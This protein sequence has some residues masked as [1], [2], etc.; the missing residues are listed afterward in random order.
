[1]RSRVGEECASHCHWCGGRHNLEL[2]DVEGVFLEVEQE[3]PLEYGSGNG[4]NI[5][6]GAEEGEGEQLGTLALK[7]A[8]GC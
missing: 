5:R 8:C 3:N 1:M 6:S 4:D 7:R 2:C